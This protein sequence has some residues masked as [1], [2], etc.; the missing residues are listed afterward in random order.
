MQPDGSCQLAGV[1]PGGCGEGFVHDG[2]RGCFPILP[3]EPC[4]PGMIALPGDEACQDIAPCG[5]GR[6]GNIITAPNT[7]HVD[8]SH[9]GSSTG[10]ATEP[11]VTIGEAIDNAEAGATVAIAAGTYRENVSVIGKPLTI[12]GR[13]PSMVQIE[14]EGGTTSNGALSAGFGQADGTVFRGVA[15]TGPIA[16]ILIE[17]ADVTIEEVWV[18]GSGLLG[19]QLSSASC[20]VRR[21]LFENNQGD[22]LTV[23]NSHAVIEAIVSRDNKPG[24]NSPGMGLFVAAENGP[25][26]ADV[27]GSVFERNTTSGIVVSDGASAAIERVVARDTQLGVLGAIG[28]GIVVS[29][30]EALLPAFA[31]IAQ[32]VVVNNWAVGIFINGSEG[33]L[34][35]VTVRDTQQGAIPSG[36][37]ILIQRGFFSDTPSV[38]SITESLVER[39]ML[40][41]VDVT[42]GTLTAQSV[43]VLDSRLSNQGFSGQG[44]AIETFSNANLVDCYI[45][46][47]YT[48]G[49]SAFESNVG[50]N[51]TVVRQAQRVPDGPFGDGLLVWADQGPAWMDVNDSLIENS[52][53]AGVANF[54]ARVSLRN[55][56]LRCQAFDLDGELDAFTFEDNGNNS[57]GCPEASDPCLVVTTGLERPD[58]VGGLQP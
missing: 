28:Q 25:S 19:A 18:H 11:F 55:T 29:D 10:S 20:S 1:R 32:S 2:S 57:C 15:V 16:G 13:C 34:H 41:G 7:M 45:E 40:A 46:G 23:H 43:A 3:A 50:V 51:R 24:A 33:Q 49:I 8:G 35:S 44:V 6:W 26:H 36:M 22:G 12:W 54:G 5:E 21:S 52:D 17:Q 58:A 31:T 47:A 53:R 37:G 56:S 30:G 42:T 4:A 38:A 27:S 9:Q 39:S 14:G 48:S